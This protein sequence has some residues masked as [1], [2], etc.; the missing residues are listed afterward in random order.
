MKISDEDISFDL[1]YRPATSKHPRRFVFT[2]V[3]D[4]LFDIKFDDHTRIEPQKLLFYYSPDDAWWNASYVDSNNDFDNDFK[5]DLEDNKVLE[6]VQGL[7]LDYAVQQISKDVLESQ[8]PDAALRKKL[9][10]V[11]TVV[12]INSKY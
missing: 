8:A 9:K 2:Y 7:W 3:P 12:R 5:Q 11:G 4:G 10:K 6:L 1:S